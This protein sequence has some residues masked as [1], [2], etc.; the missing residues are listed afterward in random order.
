ML[1]MDLVQSQYGWYPVREVNIVVCVLGREGVVKYLCSRTR[2][3][4]LSRIG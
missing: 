2:R 3:E 4:E 1:L